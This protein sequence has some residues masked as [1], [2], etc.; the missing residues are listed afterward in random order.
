MTLSLAYVTKGVAFVNSFICDLWQLS[1]SLVSRIKDKFLLTINSLYNMA[2]FTF[3]GS[4]ALETGKNEDRKLV[5]FS[6]FYIQSCVRS[7][8]RNNR[9]PTSWKNVDLMLVLQLVI[10][11][12]TQSSPGCLVVIWIISILW[13][14]QILS[15][16][17][18]WLSD[19]SAIGELMALPL[20]V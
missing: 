4:G 15:I 7:R 3:G 5:T 17:L 10:M 19:I 12:K 11:Y 2:N 16:V 20:A 9:Y 6:Q 14:S 18:Y 13:G 8:K 1:Y